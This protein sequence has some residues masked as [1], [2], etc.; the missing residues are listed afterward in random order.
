MIAAVL[1]S[2]HAALPLAVTAFCLGLL[3]NSGLPL[4]LT[5]R[6]LTAPVGM[7]LTLAVVQS[8][9]TG[10]TP[11]FSF[12]FFGH[13]LTATCEGARHGALLSCRALAAGSVMLLL[14]STTPA[15]RIFISLRWFKVPEAWVEIAMLMHR[16]IFVLLEKSRDIID[17]QKVRLGYSSI[18]RSLSSMGAMEGALLLGSI[19]QATAVFDSMRARGYNGRTPFG[20]MPD[21]SGRDRLKLAVIPLVSLG[22]CFM[23]ERGLR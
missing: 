12:T 19:D 9:S 15:D 18:G 14:S 1:L 5:R 8:F 20:E 23:F 11:M 10:S 3:F 2:S 16:Y 7:A 17:A 21:M 13:I 22:V 6:R 4:E